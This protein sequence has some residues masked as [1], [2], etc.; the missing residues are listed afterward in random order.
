MNAA[1]GETILI[2]DGQ[3]RTLCLTLR[4]L[5]E[6]ETAFGCASLSELQMRLKCLSAQELMTVLEI[7]LRA[8]GATCGVDNV[9]PGEAAKAVAEAFHAALG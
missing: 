8:G 9:S 4:A 1:R 2:V 7:L 6:L 5:A 3:R